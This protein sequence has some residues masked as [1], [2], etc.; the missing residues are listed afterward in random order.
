MGLWTKFLLFSSIYIVGINSHGRL[1]D[2]PARNSMWRFGYG[3]PINYSD[4]E[5]FCGGV[6]IQ[7]K[8][9]KG[10][11]GVCGDDW[12]KKRPRDNENGGVW[13][14]GTIGRTYMQGQVQDLI[15]ISSYYDLHFNY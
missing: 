11:C 5:V 4:N 15:T 7:F 3:T 12:S 10:K 6:G 13:G 9:N 14:T 8:K 2:P 1:M